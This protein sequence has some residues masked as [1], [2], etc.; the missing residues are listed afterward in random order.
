[1]VE[2]IA[3]C[4]DAGIRVIMA[5]GDQPATA[6][7]IG[8]AV[9]LHGAV[10][11]GSE[12]SSG[13]GELD[14]A[15]YARVTPEQKLDI[16]CAHQAAGAVVAMT[17]DGVNDAPALHRADIGIAMGKRGTDVAR[18]AAD[19]VLVDDSFASIVAAIEQGRAIF[20]NIRRFVVYLLSCNLSEV[21]VVTGAIIFG[22]PLPLLPLQILFLNLVTDVFPALAL[23]FGEGDPDAMRRPPRPPREPIVG[24]RHWLAIAAFASVITA[25]VL[26]AMA[27]A[28]RSGASA[29]EAT[30]ISFL[31]LGMAQLWHVFNLRGLRS[32][33]LDNDIVRS[34]W[35]W[36]ALAL[37]AAL[38]AFAALWPPLAGVLGVTDIGARGWAIAESMSLAP[39]VVVQ[40]ALGALS[41]R[42]RSPR[43]ARA[44]GS[45][46]DPTRG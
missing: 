40:L 23:G 33:A 27:I 37:C 8:A 1:V 39:V 18:E 6:A 12:L 30:S 13:G 41:L 19:M 4:R 20:E 28:I 42:S 35:I 5:T 26:G 29:A 45:P 32:R 34:P 17:G 15:I 10:V 14:A 46:A 3:R 2:P 43:G 7:S 11:S 25:S 21:L 9:G 24:R 44:A 22:A 38:L 16:I 31:T 36:G